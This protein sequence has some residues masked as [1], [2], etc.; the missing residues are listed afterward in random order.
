M[1]AFQAAQQ[2]IQ[3]VPEIIAKSAQS[4]LGIL[5]LMT[6]AI[7]VLSYLFFAKSKVNLRAAMFVLMLA[8][9]VAFGIA[10][11]RT[12]SLGQGQA[13]TG[14]PAG[15]EPGQTAPGAQPEPASR[16]ARPPEI[17]Q[18]TRGDG[19]PA[20]AGVK[21]SVTINYNAEPSGEKKKAEDKSRR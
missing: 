19:S 5:A 10:V 11:V 7:A 21:G 15:G 4:P 9:A 12:G 16:P 20:V 13:R 3:A 6:L 17:R 2:G 18:E 8:A 14:V 1:F